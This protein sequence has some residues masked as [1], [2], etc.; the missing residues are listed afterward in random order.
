M[1][2]SYEKVIH[3]ISR[4]FQ[5]QESEIKRIVCLKKG[6][7]NKSYLFQLGDSRYICRLPGPGTE[8]LI[9]RKEEKAS[10]DAVAHLGITDE[11]IY[12]NEKTG[13]KVTR[14]YDNVRNANSS[15]WDDMSR[16]MALVRKLHEAGVKVSHQFRIRGR[17]DFYETLCNTHGGVLEDDYAEV[18]EQMNELMDR[19]AQMDRPECFCHIDANVDNFLFLP[20]GE[21]RLLDWEYAGMCDPILDISMSAIY[22]YYTGE[23]MEYLLELYLQRKP[24]QDELFAVYAYAALGGFLWYLWSVYKGVLGEE[25]GEYPMIMYRYAK[26]FNPI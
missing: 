19:I 8:F 10:Y 2:E 20:N 26:E 24:D 11:V 5:K 22:S 3:L 25:F 9:N 13:Y 21:I 1:N 12:M 23:Q 18:R 17:I 7:T 15:A 14:Y 4:I 6:M 16:C